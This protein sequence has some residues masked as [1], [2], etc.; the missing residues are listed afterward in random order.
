MI[1]CADTTIKV[2]CFIHT[3]A[4]NMRKIRKEKGLTQRELAERLGSSKQWVSDIE[5]SKKS[6]RFDSFL[7]IAMALEVKPQVLLQ[8]W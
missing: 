4:A 7:K 8:G 1:R 5:R 6:F 3:F 2:E